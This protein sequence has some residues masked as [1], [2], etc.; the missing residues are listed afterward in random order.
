MDKFDKYQDVP[1]VATF[2]DMVDLIT[3]NLH[4]QIL[5]EFQLLWIVADPFAGHFRIGE[6][7]S[8]EERSRVS[9]E[10]EKVLPAAPSTTIM[11]FLFRVG[12]SYL[13]SGSQ[14]H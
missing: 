2:R 3:R 4:Q 10:Q 13:A 5:R 7:A 12:L 8:F 6:G 11:H 1:K 9:A 14:F